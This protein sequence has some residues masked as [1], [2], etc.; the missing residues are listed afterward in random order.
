[1]ESNRN[2]QKR[3]EKYAKRK[4]GHKQTETNKIKR[5]EQNLTFKKNRNKQKR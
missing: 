1:M 4:N 3:T 2:R 5:S